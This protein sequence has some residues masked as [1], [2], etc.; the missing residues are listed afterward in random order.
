[1]PLPHG[2]HTTVGGKHEALAG[3][4]GAREVVCLQGAYFDGRTDDY[5]RKDEGQGPAQSR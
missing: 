5:G 2:Y 4:R 1:M 3:S